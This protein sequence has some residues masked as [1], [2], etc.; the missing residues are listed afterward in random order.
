MESFKMLNVRVVV[1]TAMNHPNDPLVDRNPSAVIVQ[2]IPTASV[3]QRHFLKNNLN[4]QLQG[5]GV[6]K[7][8]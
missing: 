5:I 2:F 7:L 6:Q 8:I 1:V 3:V 4:R